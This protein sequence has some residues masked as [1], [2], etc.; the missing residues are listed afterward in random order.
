MRLC[1]LGKVNQDNL[2]IFAAGQSTERRDDLGLVNVYVRTGVA[3]GKLDLQFA[4]YFQLLNFC[5]RLHE[6]TVL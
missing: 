5:F 6:V 2:I 3:Y 4:R 1:P